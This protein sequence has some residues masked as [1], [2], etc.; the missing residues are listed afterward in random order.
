MET[1]LLCT[2]TKWMRYITSVLLF[3]LVTGFSSITQAQIEPTLTINKLDYSPGETV[4]IEGTRWQPGEII[5]LRVDHLTEPIPDHGTPDPHLEWEVTADNNGDFSSTWYVSDYEAGAELVLL[6]FGQT[7]G[8]KWEIFFTDRIQTQITSLSPNT[9][10]CGQSL[11]V[12]AKLEY[13]SSGNWIALSGQT[14]TFTLGGNNASATT[15]TQGIASTSINVPANATNLVADFAQTGNSSTGY[16]ASSQNIVFSTGM[17]IPSVNIAVTSG[18]NPTCS[19][20]SVAFTA[21]PTNGGTPSYQWKKD[22][23]NVGTNSPNYTDAGSTGG[24]ITCVMTSTDACASPTTAT[25]NS[26]ALT[27]TSNVIPSV[28]IVITAGTNPTCSGNNV[29]FTAT[30][31]N[32]G[33]PSYQWKKDGS[34]V[35]TN[36]TTY[37]DAGTTGGSITCVMTS[38]LTCVTSTTATSSSIAL[39]VTPLVTPSVSIAITSGSNPTCSGSNVTF[40]ATPT[41]GGSTPSYQWKK[42]TTDVGTNSA[43]YIDTGTTGGSI[44][45]VLTSNATCVSSATATSNSITLIVNQ[46]TAPIA[47]SSVPQCP[48]STLNLYAST[49]PDAIYSWTGPNSFGSSL[50]NPSIPNATPPATGT[51]SVTATVGGC[52][53]I[54]GTVTATIYTPPTGTISGPA[55][56]CAGSKPEL[57]ITVT[58]DGPWGGTLSDGTPDGIIPFGGSTSPITVQEKDIPVPT[59]TTTYTIASLSGKCNATSLSGSVTVTINPIPDPPTASDVSRCGPGTVTLTASAGSNTIDWYANSSGGSSLYTGPTYTPSITGPTIYYAESKNAD[60]CVS[61][62]RTMV[63]ATVKPNP[64]VTVGAVPVDAI[65]SGRNTGTNINISLSSDLPGTFSWTTSAPVGVSVDPA[66]GTGN[67]I[68]NIKNTSASNQTVTFNVTA[69]STNGC[70]IIVTPAPQVT[71]KPAPTAT[72]EINGGNP[73]CSGTTTTIKFTG[74]KDKTNAEITYNVNGGSSVSHSLNNGGNYILTTDNLTSNTTYNLVSVSDGTCTVD[75]SG[76]VTVVVN[77]PPVLNLIGNK[78]VNEEALLS[79]QATAT[80]DGF[81]IPTNTL[82][83]SLAT[84][85]SGTYPAGAAITTGGLFS[86]TPSEAQGPGVYRVEVVVSDGCTGLATDEEEFQITVNEVNVAPVLANVPATATIPE[87][88]AYSFTATATDHDIPANTLTFS[89]SAAAPA[90]SAI[91]ASSGVFTWTPAENQGPGDYTFNVRVTDNGSPVLYDEKS[92]TIHVNEVNVAPVLANVP[93]T[94][95]IPEEVAYSFT[96]TA[97]DHD[98]P[99]NILTFS[100]IGAPAGSAIGASSGVFTW[101][102]AEDQG[103]GDYTFK[104]RV[105]DDGSPVLYDEKSITIHVNE[106]NVAPVLGAIGNKT[107]PWG[108]LLT[109]TATAT[110]HDLPANILTFSLVGAPAGATINVS[111]G[112]FSWTP[113][114]AQGPGTYSFT[115]KVT[116]NGSPNLSDEESITVTVTKRTTRLVYGGASIVQYSDP[117]NLSATL[118]DITNVTPVTV[119]GLKPIDFA[120]GSQSTN[121]DPITNSSGIAS[122][123]L[124]ITQAPGGYTVTT[125]YKG[126]DSY[127]ASYDSGDPVTVNREDALV[128][129][130]GPTLVSTTSP[131]S[132]SATLTLVATIQDDPDGNRGDITN[133]RVTFTV[134]NPNGSII[135]TSP[136]PLTPSLVSTTGDKTIGTVTAAN[137]SATGVGEYVVTWVVN[138]YYTAPTT[139][140]AVIEVYQNNGDFITGGGYVIPTA[141]AGQYAS[142]PGSKTNFGFNV[143]FNKTNKNLQGSMTV[144]FRRTVGNVKHNFQIKSNSMTSLG[145]SPTSSGGTAVF[146][147]KATLKDLYDGTTYGSCILQVNMTDMGEP[148]SSDK[149]AITLYYNNALF[150]SSNW[151]STT[152][153]EMLLGGGNLLVHSSFS[154]GSAQTSGVYAR[155][156]EFGIKAY[157]NPFTDHV[158]FDLQLKT[159]SKVRLEIYTIEGSKL[160]TIYDDVVVAYDRYQFEYTPEKL[161]TGTLVYR[162]IIDGQLMFTGKL[163]HY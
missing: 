12:S 160:A 25:S 154:L 70:S 83:Y 31:T 112:V 138:N 44:T 15:N 53:S 104:V 24:S 62:E 145:V 7:S 34:P 152:T 130:T 54:A 4:Q 27:V 37:T 119:I 85:T 74:P 73:I 133:A 118:Y 121:P 137:I 103:P 122:T 38:S 136:S 63:T 127:F 45:C 131:T 159:D 69:N 100:L 93:A 6:A 84:P 59:K 98:I 116:D 9:G 60:G 114:E 139:D 96:A 124:V 94:A 95:T 72:I 43:T 125:S 65:C 8:V 123:T 162:L 51:Y 115:V 20:S 101:N 151:V 68:T 49:V 156:A 64:V 29:T 135:Y 58:G 120:I 128:N 23:S 50:Q 105:T 155:A 87:E 17:K 147:S 129:F 35:G 90:G 48:G 36:S 71:V 158:T 40:T 132:T 88:V 55:S 142:D 75:A 144:I 19:G 46:P 16:A 89:L 117:I 82:T 91:G 149:I 111:T 150:Y 41:N 157:P 153:Q 33:T 21:T 107:T 14:V 18:T 28:S 106:V 30:P 161:S 146:A 143:K 134:A 140:Q 108:N 77:T 39:T 13:K 148:G 109:F 22:G 76:S 102:P 126:D 42:G 1:L 52:S 66:S 67:I 61:A 113:T 163:M 11:P 3:L 57:K 81:G 86:W 26:I 78:V 92:I 99:A 56:V 110:D 141:S 5:I 79:F 10:E 32:G 80:D 47:S 97:T 2:K